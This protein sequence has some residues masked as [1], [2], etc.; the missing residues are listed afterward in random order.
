MPFDSNSTKILSNKILS[1]LSEKTTKSLKNKLVTF[2][3]KYG[4]KLYETGDVIDHVFFP[5]T[6]M[7]SILATLGGETMLEVGIVGYDGVVGLATFLGSPVSK[8]RAVVQG[9]GFAQKM[10]TADFLKAC[11][12]SPE[13]TKLL[14]HYAQILMTQISQSAV[15]YRYHKVEQRLARWLLISADYMQ[16]AEFRLTQDFLS[17]MLGVRR[18]GVTNAA[19]HLQKQEMISYSRGNISIIDRNALEKASCPCY[20]ILKQN[21]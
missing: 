13:L 3:L 17:H 9:Q 1:S 18:E 5:D 15:C 7:I 6:G 16:S 10:K 11:T 20:A 8:N 14:Q 12:K 19:G 4:E 21:N 2:D